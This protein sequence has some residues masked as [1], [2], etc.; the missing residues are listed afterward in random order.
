MGNTC[1]M[2]SILQALASLPCFERHLREACAAHPRDR[3]LRTVLATIAEGVSEPRQFYEALTAEATAFGGWDQHDSHELLAS[4]LNL[5]RQHIADAEERREG[6]GAGAGA[7]SRSLPV[8]AS[9]SSAA[10]AASG[11]GAGA[12]VGGGHARANVGMLAALAEGLTPA[13]AAEL[14]AM[15][16]G[17]LASEITR[18]GKSEEE[19]TGKGAAQVKAGE[20]GIAAVASAAAAPT[21]RV[22]PAT[23]ISDPFGGLEASFRRC[24]SCGFARPLSLTRVMSLSLALPQQGACALLDRLAAYT[25]QE[26]LSDVRCER[27]SLVRTLD[28]VH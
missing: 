6:D 3:F 12:S 7:G 23:S 25:E 17:D 19:G 10:A 28:R 14:Q 16:L 8:S 5:I 15:G 27:C 4:L 11:E 9:S 20:V 24:A 1:F 13:E 22:M 26:A 18:E 2:N 21:A